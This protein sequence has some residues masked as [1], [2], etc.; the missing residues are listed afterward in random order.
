M[1]CAN[2]EHPSFTLNSAQ[3]ERLELFLTSEPGWDGGN[4]KGAPTP[5]TVAEALQVLKFLRM[6]GIKTPCMFMG[7]CGEIEIAHISKDRQTY[8]NIECT[9]EGQFMIGWFDNAHETAFFIHNLTEMPEPFIQAMRKVEEMEYG[10]TD[11]IGNWSNRS[12]DSPR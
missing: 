8:L 9:G 12:E 11:E 2:I 6:H 10:P 3:W 5:A 7:S 4:A 1:N